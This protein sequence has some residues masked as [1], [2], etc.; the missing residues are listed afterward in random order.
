M[1]LCSETDRSHHWARAWNRRRVLIALALIAPA[2]AILLFGLA[3]QFVATHDLSPVA[4]VI[5]TPQERHAIDALRSEGLSVCYFRSHLRNGWRVVCTDD[6]FMDDARLCRISHDVRVLAPTTVYLS[7]T[8]VGDPGVAALS[9]T[10]SIKFLDLGWTKVGD[11]GLESI[12][13]LPL[14]KE[15]YVNNTSV[16]DRG[17]AQLQKLGG[18]RLLC[19]GR[20]RVTERGIKDF[21]QVCPHVYIDNSRR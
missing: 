19:V 8:N 14:L 3:A 6:P 9:G 16:T 11:R 18:L 5:A 15:L 1:S 12:A 21:S 17:L 2:G 7:G 13:T 10:K 4:R 20:S